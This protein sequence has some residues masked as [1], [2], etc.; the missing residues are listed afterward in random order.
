MGYRSQ[1]LLAIG[2]ELTPFLLL[3]TSQCKDAEEL[4]FKDHDIFD[5]QYC[6]G[7]LFRWDDIKWYDSY[8]G[9]AA[10][11]KFIYEA[12]SDEY[13][14][15]AD[16][17]KQNSSEYIKFVRVGEDTNDIEMHGDGFWDIH[18]SRHIEC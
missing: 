13:E 2:K 9:I 6:D 14:F 16:G 11:E 7:W 18:V 1:V 5:K 17:V 4:V 8:E 15:E 3:A 12:T 10:I